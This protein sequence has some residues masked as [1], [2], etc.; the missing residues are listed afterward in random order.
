[1]NRQKFLAL[2][3]LSVAGTSIFGAKKKESV[4]LLTDCNDPITPPVPVGPYYKDEKLN[5]AYIAEHKQGLPIEYIFL[6]EDKHCNP[7]EG[8]IVDIWQCDADGHYSDFE[9]E[10][11]TGQTWLRGFQKTGKDGKCRFTSIFPGWYNGRLTHIHA[12]VH[13][14]NQNVLTTNCFFEKTTENEVFK[15][16]LYTKGV[17]P[18]TIAQDFE[19]RGD[20]DTK[21]YDTLIMKITKGSDGMLTG[22][23]TFAIE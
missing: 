19:L 1:M 9:Q 22:R 8:A 20:K 6:V 17:N 11:T 15:H 23:Y 18:T 7:V 13:I 14:N 16:P 12:K 5:R 3:G 10:K 21:R 2:L 4:S